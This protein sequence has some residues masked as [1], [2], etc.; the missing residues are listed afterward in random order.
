MTITET[1]TTQQ[2]NCLKA[3]IACEKAISSTEVMHRYQISSTTSIS[4]S[5]AA[6]I[7]N[8]I[9]DNK[10]AE[11]SFQDP[12]LCLLVED[13]VLRKTIIMFPCFQSYFCTFSHQK[14]AFFTS[15]C[16]AYFDIQEITLT[17]T[18]QNGGTSRE[19]C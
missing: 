9:L 16:T 13:G 4:R 17:F 18:F 7:K 11:I 12:D 10:A 1:L 19:W 14:T 6:L 8:D 5:K 2:L 3:L 15:F